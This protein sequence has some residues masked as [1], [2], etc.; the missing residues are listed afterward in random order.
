MVRSS[1]VGLLMAQPTTV[2]ENKS[3]ITAKYNQHL[4][5][6]GGDVADPLL[7]GGIGLELLIE[8][9]VSYC[10]LGVWPGGDLEPLLPPILEA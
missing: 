10:A 6:N 8:K 5:N 3:K 2:L 1:L 4:A 9:V 7:L